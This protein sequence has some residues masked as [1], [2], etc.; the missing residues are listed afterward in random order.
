[1]Q[2]RIGRTTRAGIT[3][4]A[5]TFMSPQEKGDLRAIERAVK[6]SLP[7]RTLDGFGY[8]SKPA[9]RFARRTDRRDPGRPARPRNGRERRSRPKKGRF[10]FL[11]G[12]PALERSGEPPVEPAAVWVGQPSRA[13]SR[14]LGQ[15]WVG[16]VL[17]RPAGHPGRAP[18]GAMASRRSGGRA[19]RRARPAAVGVRTAISGSELGQSETWV[20]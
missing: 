14:G 5:F 3:G 15:T 1:M 7:R 2:P 17:G 11:C 6:K 18:V 16:S 9:E 13:A 10:R 8:K 12:Q 4:E 20:G 19:S